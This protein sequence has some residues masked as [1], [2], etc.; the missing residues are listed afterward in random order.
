MTR[1][2]WSEKV[3]IFVWEI[4]LCKLVVVFWIRSDRKVGR[5]ILAEKIL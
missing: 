3:E 4:E 1:D 5:R 2:F